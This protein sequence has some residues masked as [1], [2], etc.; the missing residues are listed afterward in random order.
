MFEKA[1]TSIEQHSFAKLRLISKGLYTYQSSHRTAKE[2]A[3]ALI[4]RLTSL[5]CRTFCH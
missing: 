5:Y 1:D 3:L 2:T 4:E